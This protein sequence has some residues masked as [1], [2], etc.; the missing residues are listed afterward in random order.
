[1]RVVVP[2]VHIAPGVAE[3]LDATGH[4]WEAIDVSGSDFNYWTLLSDLWSRKACLILVEHDVIVR[5]D[6]LA[7][8]EAC[9]RPWCAFTVPY[10]GGEY[11]G[12]GCVKFDA[13]IIAAIPDALDQ[14]GT[15]SNASHPP[16]HYC[17]MDHF[18]QRVVLPQTG[19]AQHV[20]LPAL[21][22]YREYEGLPQ[23]SHG[24]VGSRMK[25]TA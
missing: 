4:P 21:G 23:P 15:M 20:H 6:T 10:L 3:A 12:L 19:M 7:E 14:V 17:S 5:P 22:H 16:K 13:S 1:M 18:L 25:E 9:P 2:F 11:P 24:C 8:L